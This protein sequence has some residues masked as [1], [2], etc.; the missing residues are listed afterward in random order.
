MT[1]T[2][3]QRNILLGL[4]MYPCINVFR[5][6]NGG[7][8]DNK[9]GCY[10]KSGTW[11]P[12]GMADIMVM[13]DKGVMWIEVKKPG[14]KQSDDQIKF[15]GICEKHGVSYGVAHSLDEARKLL[16]YWGIEI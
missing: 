3:I 16:Q 10:R 11:H 12:H 14:E 4:G 2:D 8:Y 7:V 9:R 1:E 6:N 5:M 13:T 15:Q